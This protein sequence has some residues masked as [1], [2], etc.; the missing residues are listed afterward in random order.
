MRAW[1]VCATL[2]VAVAALSGMLAIA[3]A[4]TTPMDRVDIPF[5]TDA[6]EYLRIGAELD[7]A[8]ERA[9]DLERKAA[10][11]RAELAALDSRLQVT[12]QRIRERRAALATAEAELVVAQQRY[13]ERMIVVYKRGSVEALSLLLGAESLSDLVSRASIISRL[14]ADDA[15]VVASLNVAAADARFQASALE[16]LRAQDTSLRA[17]QKAR[18]DTLRDSI[19]EQE[20]TIAHLGLEARRTLREARRLD[21]ETRR[22]WRASSLPLGVPIPRAEATVFPEEGRAFLVS[23]Y[24]PVAY[25]STDQSFG[26][27]CSWY[28]N[29]FHGRGSASG[30]IFNEGDFTCA[31]RTLPFG[32]V[33]ALAN[34]ERRIIVYVN[35]RGPYVAG[36]DLDLS[37]A[38]AQ[39]LGI[40]GVGRVEAEIVVPFEGIE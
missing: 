39:A 30:Q 34:G 36:R 9:I 37:K 13:D 4:K 14:A 32:T 40:S 20:Q 18:L 3:H 1:R 19:E 33:L 24:M 16:D 10:D 26:A 17:Q 29:E 7:A 25:R 27:V 5:A 22:R 12:G 15:A 38:A 31:S 23:A 28:G 2:V 35:D 11:T 21:A 8:T 6:A